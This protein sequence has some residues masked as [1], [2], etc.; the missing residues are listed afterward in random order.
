MFQTTNQI[1]IIDG[2]KLN[3][4]RTSSN[5][6]ASPCSLLMPSLIAFNDSNVGWLCRKSTAAENRWRLVI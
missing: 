1:S 6:G 4:L 5:R 3:E 2:V